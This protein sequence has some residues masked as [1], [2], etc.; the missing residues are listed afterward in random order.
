MT[1][2]TNQLGLIPKTIS[3]MT[4]HRRRGQ[5]DPA[6]GVAGCNCAGSKRET[7]QSTKE[8]VAN[9]DSSGSPPD[10]CLAGMRANGHQRAPEAFQRDMN[11]TLRSVLLLR[12]SANGWLTLRCFHAVTRLPT[13]YQVS[14]SPMP[15]TEIVPRGSKL[16]FVLQQLIGLLGDLDPTWR[17]GGLHP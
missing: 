16:E 7:D 5:V 11:P 1:T 17:A 14:I 10:I 9:D 2:P 3:R 4:L 6:F 15:L 8:E 13:R 12:R